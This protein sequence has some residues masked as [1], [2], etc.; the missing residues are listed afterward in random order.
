MELEYWKVAES[1]DAESFRELMLTYGQ[2]VWNYA[3][4]LTN[5][6]DLADD[7]SQDVFLKVYRNIASFR[8]ESSMR[9]WL[10]AITRNISI[11]YR[12]SAFMR[13]IVLAESV[14]P[15]E[16]HPSAEQEAVQHS[17]SSELWQLVMNL[18]VKYRE[19]LVLHAKNEL[20][21]KEIAQ[22]LGVSEGTVKS[23]LSRARQ[24]VNG[25]W[26]EEWIHGRA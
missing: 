11:N 23:R 4:L 18:P 15:S 13:K 2:E 3:F 16:T 10:F 8:G 1:L 24:K 20:S 9:T 14:T 21:Q 12:R 25:A 17:L 7:I 5:R 26:K 22:L 19:V 6:A